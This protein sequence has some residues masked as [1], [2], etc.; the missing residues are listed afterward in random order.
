MLLLCAL[1]IDSRIVNFY[2]ADKENIEGYQKTSV[3]VVNP[4][5]IN[6]LCGYLDF[7]YHKYDN[8][9]KILQNYTHYYPKL[10]PTVYSIG[11]SKENRT[12]W[13]I[14][15]T[16]V[17]DSSKI[18][19]PN[20]KL[21]GNIHGN[22]AVGRELLLHLIEYIGDN[23]EK[24]PVITWIMNNTKIHILPSMNPDGFEK[25]SE[26]ICVG[27]HGRSNVRNIDLNRNFPDYYVENK[28]PVQPESI[29]IQNWMRDIPFILSACLHGGAMVVNYPFDTVKEF[30]S[31]PVNPP[32][33]SAD[34]DVFVYLA[35]VYA[36]LNPKM[37]LGLA[38][39][40]GGKN[41]TGGITNGAA[42]YPFRGGMQD[43]NYFKHGC[44]ELTL[45]ISCCKYPPATKLPQLWNDNKYA[46]IDFIKQ[47][48][49]GV[50]GVVID[51][52]DKKV[53]TKAKLQ[54]IGRKMN[55]ATSSKGEFWRILLP[56]KYKL[57]INATGY[58]S[59]IIPFEVAKDENNKPKPTILN[60]ALY[61][62]TSLK[63]TTPTPKPT[64]LFPRRVATTSTH[65]P[66]H[67]VDYTKPNHSQ[68]IRNQH[69]DREKPLNLQSLIKNST[70][71]LTKNILLNLMQTIVIV[72]YFK[73]NTL[74]SEDPAE[75]RPTPFRS[76]ESALVTSTNKS[77]K[78]KRE[79]DTK[80]KRRLDSEIQ[81]ENGKV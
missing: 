51:G 2:V 61:K 6:Q 43:F 64:T 4:V 46:L 56:G 19:I 18:A 36:G 34:D 53:I 25:A 41:F 33:L 32:S 59:D 72:I 7:V 28:L 16:A 13:V 52:E 47:S 78:K 45:E 8:L 15:L 68:D 5:Y 23:Y 75:K 74:D 24:D 66:S 71:S 11:K 35:K 58:H 1:S 10:S 80:R 77:A 3:A 14:Q 20:V 63:P 39:P 31:L 60:V 26:G 9:T 70:P 67:A 40:A 69:V 12:L 54:I 37:R 29:A 30:T 21:I 50:R 42:W 17:K 81:T 22:E 79:K 44:M 62:L 38:C 55:F 57:Q 49:R 73:E 76:S 48:Q 65:F 27:E